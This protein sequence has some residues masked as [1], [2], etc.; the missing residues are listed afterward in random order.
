[1]TLH[2]FIF[3]ML[4]VPALLLLLGGCSQEFKKLETIPYETMAE[5]FASPSSQY[6]TGCWWWWPNCNATE[7]SIVSDLNA[8]KQNGFQSALLFDGG[9]HNQ[10]GNKDVPMGPTFGSDEWLKLFLTA[11]NTADSLGIEIGFNIMSGWNLG[12]P[13]I[14]VKEAA[15]KLTYT[16]AFAVGGKE[17]NIILEQPEALL[18][19]YQDIKV[20]AFPIDRGNIAS[21][22]VQYLDYKLGVH[23][24][25]GSA[26]DCRFLLDN[27]RKDNRPSDLTP[28][29]ISSND[30]V[31]IS[32]FMS[33][34]GNLKWDAPEGEWEIMR[35]GYT[36]TGA[37]VSTATGSWQGLVL[38]YMSHDALKFYL[39]TVIDPILE[40]AGD[41][42]GRSLKY[43]YTG[44][45]E[46]GG[47]NWTEDFD[48]IFKDFNGYDILPYLPLLDG[49]VIDDIN[50]SN[51]F[52]AD[53]RKTI[54]DAVAKNHY[55]QF[56][57]FAHARGMGYL[58]ESA[59][60]HAGPLDGI[61]NYSLS[62]VVMGEFWSPSPHRPDP[63]K[64]FFMK[65]ASSAA[66]IYGK[67]V[68]GAEA[69]TTIGLHWNDLVW[70]D[71]KSSFDHEICSGLNRTYFHT[72]TTSPEAMGLPGQEYFAGTHINPRITWWKECGEFI[73]YMS[74]IHLLTQEAK[75][76]SDILYYYG[77]HV[78]NIL[79]YKHSN[80]AGN[81]PGFDFDAC[82]EEV[83][84][85][86][87]VDKDGM[88]VVPSG[89]KYR[90][91]ALPDHG[92][93]SL[94][95][96]RKVEWLIERGAAVAG[97]KAERCVSLVGGE[98][99]RKEFAEI[100]A[101]ISL[102]AT[103]AREYLLSSG[104]PCDFSV[105]ED[106]S[107]ADFDY[108]HYRFDGREMYFVSNMSSEAKSVH[109]RFRVEG[110]S[111]E[112]WDA[113]TGEI[114]P[115][116]AFSQ[117][118]GVTTLPLSFD[119]CGS[120]IIVFNGAIGGN[121]C[122]KAE[123]NTPSYSLVKTVDG[124]W[125]V[126]FDPEWGGPG[127]TVFDTLTDWTVS[128]DEGIR[129]YSGEADYRTS[130][131]IEDKIDAEYYLTLGE[132]LDVGMAYITVNGTPKGLVWTKPFR[133]K[134]SDE[135]KAGRNELE[136]RVINSWYN[137]VAGDQYRPDGKQY[138]RTNIVL[139]NDYKGNPRSEEYLSP[140][141]LLG[142]VCI[143]SAEK[144]R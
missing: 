51:A 38:D 83:L 129:F 116:E 107:L 115:L 61:K 66:H 104:V 65:Q 106:P 113:L 90:V 110:R 122:G 63:D 45:W 78:P 101:R 10:R 49:V 102:D 39:E 11:V 74:R 130:F 44:S 62:D 132:V 140:S 67:K 59:G 69:F 121:V 14:T 77:D 123:T 100:A 52:L 85:E 26:P 94:A 103:N 93:L 89:L 7:E 1:M 120:M 124:P 29:I 36:C 143:W 42:V 37:K 28:Y 96:I 46:C 23:E 144:H 141:G 76:V 131:N 108:I 13:C 79:P 57:D 114:R 134:I 25:G 135:L 119:P 80:I 6:G 58:P 139:L 109:C 12:G 86:L 22:P 21:E 88:L 30:V 87:D 17:V 35:L 112:L 16:K 128:D 55:K 27:E 133:V 97:R 5:R 34:D 70:R 54:A 82:G 126:S 125:N 9:G 43:L 71:M 32:D 136:V 92:V 118:N 50:K 40:A 98:A 99:A 3:T 2:R 53:F 56:S 4:V 73:R 127:E 111:P 75:P 19:F 33:E 117:E 48:K 84:L 20:L 137:R 105:A 68:V 81:M 47:M 91:L 64:R 142:P 41:K 60:P 138:T 95:A 18:D 15:K 8:M 24:L 31:D 72:L